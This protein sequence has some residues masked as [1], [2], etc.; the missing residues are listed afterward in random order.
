MDDEDFD[1][2]EVAQYPEWFNDARCRPGSG[3]DRDV[4]FMDGKNSWLFIPPKM[5][6]I[7]ETPGKACPVRLQCLQ[8]GMMEQWGIF[9]GMSARER[10][11][12]K[13]QIKRGKSVHQEIAK[14]D[15]I[16][17]QRAEI[18]K[19]RE[20]RT[21]I[22]YVKEAKRRERNIE[23]LL[24]YLNS[25]RNKKSEIKHIKAFMKLTD[26]DLQ[27]T[28]RIARSRGL[29]E[30]VYPAHSGKPQTWRLIADAK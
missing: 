19:Q 4:F 1:L 18:L 22:A 7:G 27:D 6:C 9:G 15:K 3:I 14:L 10:G 23:K 12:L 13:R 30:P 26:E 29:I 17:R 24:V 25:R 2:Y 5:I 21:N 16:T 28:I 11:Q 8:Y 20:G